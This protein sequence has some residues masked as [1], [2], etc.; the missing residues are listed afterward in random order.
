M[1]RRTTHDG[2]KRGG[3]WYKRARIASHIQFDSVTSELEQAES[4]TNL[5]SNT[6]FL[7]QIK[8]RK[9][10]K[11]ECEY[12]DPLS[13]SNFPFTAQY[14]TKPQEPA[15]NTVSFATTGIGQGQDIVSNPKQLGLEIMCDD[16][17]IFPDI[18]VPQTL[19]A[20]IDNLCNAMRLILRE[21]KI[22]LPQWHLWGAHPETIP[23]EFAF[24]GRGVYVVDRR[25]PI[26][27]DKGRQRE[28]GP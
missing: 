17:G 5:I 1:V 15:E 21:T 16:P 14:A 4:N 25:S 22:A 7:G 23:N 2:I 26:A 11:N 13:K 19:A 10:D 8:G 18:D 12:G 3:I 6:I 28:G 24:F 20:D 27:K 9:L